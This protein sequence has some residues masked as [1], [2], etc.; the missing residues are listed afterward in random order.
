M[1]VTAALASGFCFVNRRHEPAGYP[2]KRICLAN[3]PMLVSGLLRSR[4]ILTHCFMRSVN[5]DNSQ[6][7]IAC[8]PKG[9]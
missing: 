1:R 5:G 9:G 6:T 7:Q 4:H 2:Q 3:R 8:E